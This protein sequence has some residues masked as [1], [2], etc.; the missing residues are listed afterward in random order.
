MINENMDDKYKDIYPCKGTKTK[1]CCCLDTY[2]EKK[3]STKS[4]NRFKDKDEALRFLAGIRS[5]A[6]LLS[7]AAY[8]QENSNTS[9]R[10]R[11][12]TRTKRSGKKKSKRYIEYVIETREMLKDDGICEV[13]CKNILAYSN[14]L[15]HRKL[16]YDPENRNS[17][18]SKAKSKTKRRLVK[19]PF[20]D[21]KLKKCCWRKC[22]TLLINNIPSFERLR[23][24]AQKSNKDK[25][26]AIQKMIYYSNGE[27]KTCNKFIVQVLGCSRGTLKTVK[28]ELAD[29]VI[30]SNSASPNLS[31]FVSQTTRRTSH[32]EASK[33]SQPTSLK[34]IPGRINNSRYQSND[35]STDQVINDILLS[36]EK[37]FSHIDQAFERKTNGNLNDVNYLLKN[38]IYSQLSNPNIQTP[39]TKSKQCSGQIISGNETVNNNS[40]P[41]PVHIPY[42]THPVP[43]IQPNPYPG[44]VQPPNNS[45]NI[46]FNYI[47][48]NEQQYKDHFLRDDNVYILV[49]KND[50]DFMLIKLTHPININLKPYPDATYR[51]LY[52][53]DLEYIITKYASLLSH[54]DFDKIFSIWQSYQPK[55]S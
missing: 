39:Q 52:V 20:E 31:K 43:R 13:A 55:H 32:P 1:K 9:K 29:T 46:P 25:R 50:E 35:G 21:L 12:G 6:L 10:D 51:L 28:K 33:R 42:Y 34:P 2:I 17:I 8:P 41:Q 40:L 36:T 27:R 7:K 37:R 15:I 18:I 45:Q 5:T 3:I 11:S 26:T 19:I 49:Q 22:T 47:N 53:E 14:N 24:E 48:P 16:K 23:A 38:G 30:S 4:D 44:Y 54:D